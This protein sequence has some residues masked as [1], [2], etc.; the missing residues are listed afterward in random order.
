MDKKVT[1]RDLEQGVKEA[2]REYFEYDPDAEPSDAA[3]EAAD[4]WVPPYTHD[5]MQLAADNIDLAVTEPELGPAFDGSPTPVNIIAAN[6]YERLLDA[7]WEVLRE[8]EEADE[9]PDAKE[10][11]A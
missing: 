11:S 6:I 2:V 1:L 5:L 8:I 7:A 3:H 10:A 9:E 4:S